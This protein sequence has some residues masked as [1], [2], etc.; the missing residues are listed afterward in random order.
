MDK[1][2]FG[3]T[4]LEVSRLCFGTEPFT[5][6]KGTADQKIGGDVSPE[7]AGRML[8][9][10]L[11]LGVNFWDTS[12]DYG[13]HPHVAEGLRLVPRREVVIAD[14]S[15]AKTTEDAK[16]DLKKSLTE[17]DTDYIDIML[18]HYVPYHAKREHNTLS[19]K[20]I[21]LGN[22]EQRLE[23][24][25]TFC[26]AKE[27]GVVRAVGLST[28]STKVVKAASAMPEIDV[29]CTILNKVGA[30]IEDGTLT[31]HISA[32]KGAYEAGKA[33]YVI[34][35]LNA[36]KLRSK[37]E[38]SLRFAFQQHLFINAF[39]IGM[40]SVDEVKTNVRLLGAVLQKK[41]SSE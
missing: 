21:E 15:Y 34:K 13:T 16:A 3:R 36:G 4:K 10:A 37:S 17:L 1:I 40:Y 33:V 39:N 38:S 23:A 22:L 18:L 28:H 12:N 20:Y 35:L 24:L 14:K 19:T 27:S 31:E 2:R 7:K 26:E 30:W 32:I 41:L 6:P 29:I 9:N 8:K 25:K 11:E 5:I